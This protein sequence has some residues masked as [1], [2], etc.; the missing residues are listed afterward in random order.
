MQIGGPPAP[1]GGIPAGL[2]SSTPGFGVAGS[3]A[4]PQGGGSDR[5]IAET[6]AQH[7]L[8]ATSQAH[9]PEL[10]AAFSVAL[11]ALHKYIAGIDKE[12]HQ[13]LGGKLSPRL[14][15]QAHGA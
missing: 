4:P 13:A 6:A 10:K 8:A 9:D 11:A 5:S 14:M 15:A 7:L 3:G 2:P 1:T 12:H